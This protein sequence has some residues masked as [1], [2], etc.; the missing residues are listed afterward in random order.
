MDWDVIT[1]IT[2]EHTHTLLMYTFSVTPLLY[3]DC[4]G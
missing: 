1:I 3:D 4:G 2:H